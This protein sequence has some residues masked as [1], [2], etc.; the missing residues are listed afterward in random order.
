MNFPRNSFQ[1]GLNWETNSMNVIVDR[2]R[3]AWN[4]GKNFVKSF[5]YKNSQTF[6]NFW[7]ENYWF[8]P[9]TSLESVQ[10]DALQAIL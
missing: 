5:C 4:L 8:V 3:I 9:K 10:E 7:S 2:S 6:R 1:K